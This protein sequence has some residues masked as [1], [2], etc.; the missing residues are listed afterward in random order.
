VR[1]YLQFS[2]NF[3]MVER[4]LADRAVSVDDTTVSR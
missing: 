1:W 4:M 2:I 3:R